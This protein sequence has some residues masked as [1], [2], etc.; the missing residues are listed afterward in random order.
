ML[1]PAQAE[2]WR[3]AAACWAHLPASAQDAVVAALAASGDL[4]LPEIVA[5]AEAQG[6]RSVA[7]PPEG[8]TGAQIEKRWLGSSA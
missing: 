3:A 5:L 7:V 1:E 8:C 4:A 6:P 2:Y